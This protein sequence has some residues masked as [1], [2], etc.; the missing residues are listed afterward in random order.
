MSEMTTFSK[1]G[2]ETEYIHNELLPLFVRVEARDAQNKLLRST[3]TIIT[4]PIIRSW[5]RR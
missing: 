5:P 3:R 1:R 4:T 2:F